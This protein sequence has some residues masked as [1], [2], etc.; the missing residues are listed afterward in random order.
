M[1]RLV[2]AAA[3]VAHMVF[4]GF[5]VIGGLLAWIAPGFLI[6]HIAAAMW[7]GRMAATRA[8]CPLSRIED[9]G[10]A[11]AGLPRL[12]E[13]GFIAH[14]FEGRVY[15]MNWARRVEV[16]AGSL[17]IGSWLGLALR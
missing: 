7:S 4:V 15:P 9:W 11:H 5:T 2:V 3:L 1:H 13:H 12:H 8:S 6:P 17:V 14:Y 10:R 16:L